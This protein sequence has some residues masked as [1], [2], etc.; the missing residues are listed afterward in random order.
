MKVSEVPIVIMIIL[1]Q[2]D[3]EVI[4]DGKADFHC[5]NY[6]CLETLSILGL[7]LHRTQTIETLSL[8]ILHS[9]TTILT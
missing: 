5:G 2:G 7:Q 4:V 1:Q 9:K 3:Q 8:C 6:N